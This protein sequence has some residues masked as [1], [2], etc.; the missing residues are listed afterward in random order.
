MQKETQYLGFIISEDGIMADPDKFKVMRWMLPPTCVQE[1]RN[2]IGMCSYYRRF[3][4]NFSPIV[5]P[6]F[7]L[8]K[9]FT[10]FKWRKEWQAAVDF[11]NDSLEAVPILA[12][13]DTS[14]P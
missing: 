5:K 11:L 7:R 8:T 4:P 6:F 12:Y 14:R 3:I 9:K 1:V 10:K 13:P 2:F